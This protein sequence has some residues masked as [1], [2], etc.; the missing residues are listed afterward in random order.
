MNNR[1]R[2]GETLNYINE[3]DATIVS[4]TAVHVGCLIGV[5]ATDI[6]PGAE[7]ALRLDGVYEL[8]KTAG[9]AWTL[10][11]ALSFDPATG[12]FGASGGVSGNACAFAA[13]EAADETGLVLINLGPAAS[14]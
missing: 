4:G 2:E 6:E 7:G 5:A 13:A 1:I 10:G 12:A 14:A 11:Q 8:P 9:E 3:T